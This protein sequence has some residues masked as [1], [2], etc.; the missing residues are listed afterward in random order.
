MP[1]LLLWPVVT[2][3]VQG[4][5]GFNFD[6]GRALVSPKLIT[7]RSGKKVEWAGR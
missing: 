4:L 7:H 1:L 3:V 6:P 5:N 2:L